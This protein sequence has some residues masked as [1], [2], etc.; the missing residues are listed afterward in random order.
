LLNFRFNFS[1][2]RNRYAASVP[3][4]H[5]RTNE[6]V[7]PQEKYRDFKGSPRNKRA[8]IRP[9]WNVDQCDPAAGVLGMAVDIGRLYIAKNETQIF[10][11]AAAL[12]A[13]TKLNGTSQGITD[14]NAAAASSG[15]SWNLNSTT[16]S[17][18]TTEFATSSTGPWVS[19]PGSPAGYVYVRVS[20][21]VTL[22][23]YFIPMVIANKY[24]QA[25]TSSSVAAQVPTSSIPAGA[26]PYSL[27]STNT[28]GPRFGLTVGG[29]YSIQWPNF[30][31]NRHGCNQ[32]N[33]DR[34]FNSDPCLGDTS[35]SKWAVASNWSSS[36]S[37]YW[38]FN[39]N[40]DI[41]R[42]VLNGLQAA[43]VAVGD[44]ILSLMTS[45]NKAAQPRVLDQRASQDAD[46][47]SS[48]PI[49]YQESSAHN[50]RRIMLVPILNPVSP[51]NTTVLGWGA[52]LL[53]SNGSTSNYYQRNANGNDPYC[54]VYLGPY[55]V[56]ST[57]AGAA[58]SGT[59]ASRT[60]LVF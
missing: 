32:D 38:G 16:A 47:Q 9:D 23:L 46:Y 18:F 1:L 41:E 37:G 17:G 52:I 51:S 59:G 21:P 8:R 24:T 34:C 30:N 5:L 44:N 26:S 7:V 27:V 45:G 14:A 40:A 20:L 39:S 58:T 11:D 43:P 29:S 53:Y 56:G 4:I 10:T 50:G 6:I 12:A 42:S 48:T 35:A 19:N 28:T 36:K 33:P 31:G 49:D 22:P 2:R 55:N 60:K 57:G 25:V 13:A 15:N 54:A 3:I